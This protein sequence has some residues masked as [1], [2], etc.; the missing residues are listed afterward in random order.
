MLVRELSVGAHQVDIAW[1]RHDNRVVA[2]P[3]GGSRDIP[4]I[5]HEE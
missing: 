2:F 3:T 4:V 1:E 5:L